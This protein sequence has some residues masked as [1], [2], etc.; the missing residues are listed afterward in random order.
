MKKLKRLKKVAVKFRFY[1]ILASVTSFIIVLLRLFVFASFKVP[2]I[3]MEPTIIPGD[4]VFVNKQIPGPRIITNF[5]SVQRSKNLECKRLKGY[6]DI[7][8]ND[9]LVFNYPYVDGGHITLNTSMNIIK[10]CVAIPGD[11]FYIEKGIYKVRG[12]MDTL[13]YYK[14]QID[15]YKYTIQ[16]EKMLHS[17]MFSFSKQCNWTTT[18]FGPLYVPKR[19][20]TLMVDGKSILPYLNLVLYETGGELHVLNDTVWLNREFL[21][22]YVF[23]KNYYFMAGA[24]PHNSYDSRYWG[25]LPEDHIIG[26][27]EFIWKSKDTETRHYRWNRMCKML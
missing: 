4:Y 16:K 27:A 2:S 23:Q 19:G 5:T 20:D 8:H 6:R 17:E 15:Y 1:L 13:G 12:L 21:Q 10:R 3:S 26:K 18:D 22:V 14:G 11:T 25:L 9:I 7:H 24:S